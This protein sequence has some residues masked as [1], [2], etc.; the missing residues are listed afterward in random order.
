MRE[1]LVQSPIFLLSPPRS[2]STLLRCILDSHSR[3][4]SPHEL[5][6]TAQR[7]ECFSSFGETSMKASGLTIRSTEHLLWDRILHRSLAASGKEIIVEKTPTNV[8]MWER[9]AE[10]WPDARFIFL[11]RHPAAVAESA[12]AAVT[13][14]GARDGL[15]LAR[16][17]AR[18]T[19][20]NMTKRRERWLAPG[21]DSFME[22]LEAARQ[23]LPG[24]TV[25]YEDLATRPAEVV[26]DLCEFIGVDF[27]PAM[28]DYGNGRGEYVPGIGD[29][30]DKIK[31]GKIQS[32]APPPASIP[33]KLRPVALAWGYLAPDGAHRA[34]TGRYDRTASN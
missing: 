19:V 23:A 6:L 29:W 21:L 5:Y 13:S 2:G 32:P 24:R 11:I 31:S 22:K 10:C 17:I 16:G 1:R 14:I 7:I 18:D 15:K 28:L 9:I 27:E 8:H 20:R 33:A 25:R 3:I 34:S 12:V 26:S 30:R 4:H